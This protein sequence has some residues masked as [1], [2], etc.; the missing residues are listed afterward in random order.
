MPSLSKVAELNGIFFNEQKAL[1]FLQGEGILPK[2]DT[3]EKCDN[4]TTINMDKLLLRCTR[5]KCRKSV[6]IRKG[7]FFA[8]QCFSFDEI[9]HLAYLWLLKASVIGSEAPH[10]KS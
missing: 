9:L 5:R 6:A 1:L 8:S 10:S 4:S 7:M 2:E 3:C